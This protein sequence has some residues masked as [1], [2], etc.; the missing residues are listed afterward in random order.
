M[1]R[2]KVN[3]SLANLDRALTRLEEALAVDLSNPMAI[4]AT[5]QHFEFSIELFWKTIKRCLAL[6]GIETNTPRASLK[7]AYQ[8]GWL[9][10]ESAWLEML[11]DRNET[12][13]IYD[14]NTALRI[15]QHIKAHFSEMRAVYQT[16]AAL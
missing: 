3:Q 8:I 5:I 10:D 15:Y 12:S 4:D 14:E 9:N 6:Q 7:A 16:L 13:H 11:K 1:N 2:I